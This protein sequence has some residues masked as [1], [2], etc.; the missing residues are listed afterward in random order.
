MD[1][2][3]IHRVID[4]LK[5]SSGLR[6]CSDEFSLETIFFTVSSITESLNLR[7]SGTVL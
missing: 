3:L 1:P 4:R 5:N 6:L 7:P 2:H